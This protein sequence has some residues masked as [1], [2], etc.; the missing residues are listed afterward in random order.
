[1]RE[2]GFG[3]RFALYA[4]SAVSLA[5]M[6]ACGGGGVDG[7]I[8][9]PTGLRLLA[10]ET[11]TVPGVATTDDNLIKDIK[12]QVN[13]LD[14]N[15]PELL[16]SNDACAIK[17]VNDRV[18]TAA[19]TTRTGASRW[20]CDLGV[21]G[22]DQVDKSY[23]YNLMLTATTDRNETK[24]FKHELTVVP[25]P[26]A[27]P[28]TDNYGAAGRDFSISMGKTA[29]L[30]CTGSG[31]T[32][33]YSYQWLIIDNAGLPLS[34]SS[35]SSQQSS[36]TAPAVKQATP[37]KIGCRVTDAK[38]RVRNSSVI[39]TITPT[40]ADTLVASTPAGVV[41]APGVPTTI[42]GTAGWFDVLGNT[43]TG[44]IIKYQWSLGTGAPAGTKL[45]TTTN[46]DTQLVAPTNLTEPVYIPVIF[47]ATSV[48]QTSS[49]TVEVLVDP[50]GPLNLT[51]EPAAQNVAPGDIVKIEGKATPGVGTTGPASLYYQWTIIT[52]PAVSLGGANTKNVQFVAPSV[53]APT[54]MTLRLAVGYKPITASYPGIYFSD[55]VV[56]IGAGAPPEVTAAAITPPFQS[57]TEGDTVTAVGSSGGGLYHKWTQVSGPQALTLYGVNTTNLSFVAPDVAANEVYVLRYATSKNGPITVTNPGIYEDTTITVQPAP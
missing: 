5:A 21:I 30:N 8:D 50:F 34:L 14:M 29:P 41:A 10:G 11:M 56:Q 25:N 32:S 15:A 33:P 18:F 6:S 53:T 17:E 31:G 13:A 24:T 46:R 12:W 43:G 19:G 45:L 9:A 39:V 28:I 40:S 26:N 55:A 38:N 36:L 27:A 48:G 4:I 3:K 54:T 22:P 1:M 20:V 23:K 47:T 35:Y 51:L 2:N 52:G 49:S 37:V 57:V 42:T 44:P 7:G 16:L